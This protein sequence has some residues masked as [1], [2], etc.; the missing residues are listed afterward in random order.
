MKKVVILG[1][2]VAGTVTANN[3]ATKMA[4]EVRNGE[5]QPET[6]LSGLRKQDMSLLEFSKNPITG[7]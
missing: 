2:G 6:S 7:E 1:G 5:D 4:D 3:L